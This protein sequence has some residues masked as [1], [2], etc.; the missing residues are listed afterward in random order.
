MTATP[1]FDYNETMDALA[2]ASRQFPAGSREE[3][4]IQLAARLMLFVAGDRRQLKAFR[5]WL[6]AG[7]APYTR[8]HFNASHEFATQ[9]EADAWRASGKATDGERVI[10][11]GKGYEVVEVPPYG[12]KFASVPLPEELAAREAEEDPPD[13]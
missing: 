2:S 1:D 7:S 13:P 5:N 12:L 3:R 8:A 6:E 11:A 4:A 9:E 10:I